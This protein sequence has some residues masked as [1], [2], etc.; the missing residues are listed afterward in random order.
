[1]RLFLHKNKWTLLFSTA[2]LLIIS[3]CRK[4]PELGP[5][6][7]SPYFFEYPVIIE[8][9]LPPI[10]VPDQNPMTEEGV[11]LGR[12]LFFDERL[13]ADNTQSCGSCHIPT[14]S[15]SDT[16]TF[17]IGIDGIAGNRNSMPLINLGWMNN[18]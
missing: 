9:Y 6:D 16:S 10:Q 4:D 2:V 8:D 1:M 7:A 17:S 12:K 14:A 11:E 18:L 3:A 13:S 15:F 5:V